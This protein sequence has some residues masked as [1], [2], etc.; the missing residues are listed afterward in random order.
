MV[1]YWFFLLSL[2]THVSYDM[3]TIVSYSYDYDC[4]I[5]VLITIVIIIYGQL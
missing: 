4:F 3:V 5:I 2:V 1:V